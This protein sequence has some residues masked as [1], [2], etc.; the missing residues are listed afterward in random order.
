M[1]WQFFRISTHRVVRCSAKNFFILFGY[2]LLADLR[3]WY[4]VVMYDCTLIYFHFPK[5]ETRNPPLGY[6]FS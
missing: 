5:M 6:G 4:C 2:T 3:I 1:G